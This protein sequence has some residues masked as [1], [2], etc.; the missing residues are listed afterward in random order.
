MNIFNFNDPPGIIS[1]KFSKENIK[2]AVRSKKYFID[3][4]KGL[5]NEV[6]ELSIEKIS[7]LFEFMR[8]DELETTRF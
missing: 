6:N 8:S 3:I 7:S 5:E 2:S 1:G 4:S